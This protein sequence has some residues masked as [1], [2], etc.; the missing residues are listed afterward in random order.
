MQTDDPPPADLLA[1]NALICPHCRALNP[2]SAHICRSCGINLPAY[3]A[4]RTR[5]LELQRDASAEHTTRLENDVQTTVA[6]AVAQG[7]Q[8][9]ASQLRILLITGAALAIVIV[10]AVLMYAAQLKQ[11]REQLA[12]QNE[13]ALTCLAHQ[14]YLCARDKFVAVLSEEPDYPEAAHKLQEARYGL[15]QQYTNAGQ[16]QQAVDNLDALLLA[17]PSQQRAVDLLHDVYDRWLKDA[18]ARGDF[19]TAIQV[20]I[21][22][23][24]RFAA[25]TPTPALT[26]DIG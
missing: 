13:Q 14:D 6:H 1:D 4:S 18:L 7:R 11:R 25:P 23:D 17:D 24:A 26:T 10:I 12:T 5:L 19:L 21:Q 8:Q 15:A 20:K 3:Q 22:R 9:L 16:W 2:P